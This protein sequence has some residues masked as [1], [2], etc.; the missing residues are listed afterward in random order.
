M[1]IKEK[2]NELYE[3]IIIGFILKANGDN[4]DGRKIG[5]RLYELISIMENYYA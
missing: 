5:A 4:Q 1:R 3:E 2:I